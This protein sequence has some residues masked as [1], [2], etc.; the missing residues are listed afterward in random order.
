MPNTH[1]NTHT[2][3]EPVHKHSS[4]FRRTR[5]GRDVA[6]TRNR[7]LSLGTEGPEIPTRRGALP[8]PSSSLRHGPVCFSCSLPPSVPP[9][10][11]SSQYIS[12]NTASM[13]PPRTASPS[14]V[15]AQHTMCISGHVGVIALLP[16][17]PWENTEY[18]QREVILLNRVSIQPSDGFES[19]WRADRTRTHLKRGWGE[20]GV[21]GALA[22]K[23]KKA[24]LYI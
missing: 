10:G 11:Q 4:T 17:L 1:T 23:K 24:L 3:C 13:F 18:W 7:R 21:G 14:L 5:T 16:M 2:H 6:A 20:V 9:Y 19:V 8:P 22:V 12:S 15:L